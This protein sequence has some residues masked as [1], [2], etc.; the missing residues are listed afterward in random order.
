MAEVTKIEWATHTW[1]PWIGCSHVHT[2][3]IH[4]YAEAGDGHE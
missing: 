3:C 1:N 4:C 2:G